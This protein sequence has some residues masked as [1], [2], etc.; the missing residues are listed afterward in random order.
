MQPCRYVS[1]GATIA[2]ACSYNAFASGRNRVPRS[3]GA[4]SPKK[5]EDEKRAES[6]NMLYRSRASSTGR[7]SQKW[8]LL[9][10]R[11]R[12]RAR[13]L[14]RCNMGNQGWILSKKSSIRLND[15]FCG[16]IHDILALGIGMGPGSGSSR[17]KGAEGWLLHSL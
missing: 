1:V 5:S 15:K 4:A 13:N 8:D 16:R 7:S 2:R 3:I 12:Y 17:P 6:A 9:F 11:S 14:G 10:R